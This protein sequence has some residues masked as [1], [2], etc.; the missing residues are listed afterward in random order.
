MYFSDCV[1]SCAMYC[2]FHRVFLH[3]NFHISF[4]LLLIAL[5]SKR[6]LLIKQFNFVFI[7]D[8]PLASH[9]NKRAVT[10]ENE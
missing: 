3:C 7:K 4:S 10:A 8:L 2:A 9:A 6:C 5:K 1:V